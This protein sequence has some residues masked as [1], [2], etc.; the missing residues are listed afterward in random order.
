MSLAAKSKPCAR[1][2]RDGFLD[3]SAMAKRYVPETGSTLVDF[4]FDHVAEHRV[5]V[6]NIGCAE[7]VSGSFS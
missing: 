6:L 5:Y 4:L 3:A 2:R 1:N 7:V